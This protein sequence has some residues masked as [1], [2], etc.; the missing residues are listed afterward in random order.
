ML[1]LRRRRGEQ[2]KLLLFVPH[3]QSNL[4]GYTIKTWW[5]KSSG[6]T[7]ERMPSACPVQSITYCPSQYESMAVRGGFKQR[8]RELCDKGYIEIYCLKLITYH[9]RRWC[10]SR[11]PLRETMTTYECWWAPSPNNVREADMVAVMA[12][13]D[14]KWAK[15][16]PPHGTTTLLSD[17][18]GP[19]S[20]N[21]EFNKICVCA[22]DI[23]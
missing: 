1:K 22:N 8:S 12:A 10:L 9:C 13:D 7:G 18:G 3:F 4:C 23:F 21:K 6:D 2:S 14:N 17:V 15:W 16:M 19:R 5:R 20:K 11:L